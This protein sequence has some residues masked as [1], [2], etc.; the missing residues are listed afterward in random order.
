MKALLP[1]ALLLLV[2]CRSTG[3]ATEVE[4][5]PLD[6]CIVT[7]NALRSMGGPVV[8]VHEG[9]EFKFCCSPC[10]REFEADPA[11]FAQKLAEASG[12]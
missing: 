11:S 7:G 1:L 8:K 12:H 4:P 9:Q 10:V 5:Y 6:V 2:A 3:G